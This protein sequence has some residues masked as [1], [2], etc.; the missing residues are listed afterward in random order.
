MASHSDSIEF[1]DEEEDTSRLTAADVSRAVV[2]ATDWTTETIISQMKKGNIELT[3]KFQRRDAWR[4]GRKSKFIESLVLGLPVPQLVLAESKD[5]RGSFIVLDGKQRLLTILQYTGNAPEAERNGF[6]LSGLQV[7]TDLNRKRYSDI[8][9][10][11][12]HREDVDSLLN[13]TIRTVV[14]RSW[15]NPNFLH[16]VFL[17]LNTGS[18]PLSPQELRQALFPGEFSSYAD[19]RASESRELRSLMRLTSPDFR[20][21]D[22]ELF[23]RHIAFKTGLTEY[24]GELKDFLDATCKRLNRD[25]ATE[26]TNVGQIFD[27]LERALQAA[28]EIF[29]WAAVARKWNGRDFEGSLNRA[30]F[31]A[32]TYYLSE[33]AIREAALLHAAEV[34]EAYKE[35]CV[36]DQEFKAAIES[37][38]K[39]V[40]ATAT[41][42][43]RWGIVLQR[44][45]GVACRLPV[46]DPGA[47][48]IRLEG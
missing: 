23:V 24:D 28:S 4:A 34:V 32:L 38:T 8:Q 39:T 9:G 7:R 1:Q 3:P 37:T 27:E 2:T 29:G 5:R 42:I 10:N 44:I 20:M 40:S 13:Q 33:P 16:T 15:P 26:A 21:R 47:T 43:G 45:T 6:A 14:I 31:D 12:R 30:L 22:V 41:R 17:R 25:W 35:L 18:L 46:V 19:D 48:R 36:H 11:P